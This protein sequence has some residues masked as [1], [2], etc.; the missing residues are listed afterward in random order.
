MASMQP[1][2]VLHEARNQRRLP[3]P[4]VVED[5]LP[6]DE[7]PGLVVLEEESSASVSVLALPS[8]VDG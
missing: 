7:L 5:E 2:I 3:D 6:D 4:G 1:E 8:E